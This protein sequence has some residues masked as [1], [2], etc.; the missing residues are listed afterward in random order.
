MSQLTGETSDPRP[1]PVIVRASK[2][3]L[4]SPAGPGTGSPATL[5]KMDQMTNC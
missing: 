5:A 1:P 3:T 4:V 2:H